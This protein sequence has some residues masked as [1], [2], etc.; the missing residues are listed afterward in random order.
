MKRRILYK[1]A[2]VVF[3][4]AVISSC[5]KKPKYPTQPVITY[6][7]FLRYGASSNPDSVELVVSFT[8]NEGDIGFGQEDI[9]NSSLKLG[10]FF[11]TYFY[12]S[13]GIWAAHDYTQP[14]LPPF[15][16]LKIYYWVPPVLQEGDDS[17]P[18][19]GLIYV[20]LKKLI[21][22]NNIPI[23]PDKKIKFVVNMYDKAMHKSNTIET[24]AI[25]F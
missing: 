16:T 1:L 2:I 12:D 9:D 5:I 11:M 25:Q 6:K 24:P 7:D 23:F 21:S 18:M 4:G 17:E 22:P 20:K 10:N 8:D 3:A 19:K 14:P 15:D 13:A